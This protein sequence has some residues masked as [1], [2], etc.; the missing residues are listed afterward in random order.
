MD[1]IIIRKAVVADAEALAAYTAA[2]VAEDLGTITLRVPFTVEEERQF[3]A[4]NDAAERAFA[5]LAMDR[6]R[7]VGM[8]DLQAG[9]REHERHAGRFGMSVA[10]DW[11]GKG[12]GRRL[13]EAA[14]AETRAWPGFCRLELEVFPHNAAAIRLYESSG[15]VV[16]ARKEKAI[17]LR[18][19]PEDI[20]LMALVW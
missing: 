15:F 13:L 11:R 1:E 2:L 7:V 8:L 18:G 6:S 17:N 14:I 12:L 3:I 5:M 9:V 19:Q 20:L 10:R 16:E 4:K